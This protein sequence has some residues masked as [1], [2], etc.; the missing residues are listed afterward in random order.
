MAEKLKLKKETEFLID[1][2][3]LYRELPVLWNIK[4]KE[5][6]DRDKK[7]T[8]YETL[9]VKYK[10]MFPDATKD[11]LKKKIEFFGNKL[12]EGA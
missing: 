10:E 7:N 4:S 5:Y 1:C 9:F 12:Q 11:D 6:H 3:H 8:A 2:I